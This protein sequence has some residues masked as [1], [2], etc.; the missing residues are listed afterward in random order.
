MD[1]Q[2][3]AGEGQFSLSD[4]SVTLGNDPTVAFR[5]AP[6]PAH[7]E[8]T[9]LEDEATH[10]A[11]MNIMFWATIAVAIIGGLALAGTILL[12]WNGKTVPEGLPGAVQWSLAI[13]GVLLVG[14]ALL[15]K[16]AVK[17]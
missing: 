3:T 7:M 9:V 8:Q 6:Q 16:L 14:D 17:Q 15:G 1:G 2:I 5:Q 10:P 4:G 13:L 12:A 11:Y